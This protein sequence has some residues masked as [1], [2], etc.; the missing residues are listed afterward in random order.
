MVAKAAMFTSHTTAP[1][2]SA[3]LIVSRPTAYGL[4]R[5]L[6]ARAKLAVGLEVGVFTSLAAGEEWL[7][8]PEPGH[9]SRQ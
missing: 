8:T 1:I 3:S 4:M 9:E 2:F 6:G 7:A 5:V